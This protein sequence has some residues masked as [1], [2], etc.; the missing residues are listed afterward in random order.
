M[1]L[2][3]EPKR[4]NTFAVLQITDWHGASRMRPE[5]FVKQNGIP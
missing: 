2:T 5:L 4:T 3:A 1:H